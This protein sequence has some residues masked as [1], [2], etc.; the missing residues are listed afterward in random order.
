MDKVFVEVVW[1]TWAMDLGIWRCGG[2]KFAS[3]AKFDDGG[4]F[5]AR[6]QVGVK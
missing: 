6:A 5:L 4:V 3:R 2:G 1:A